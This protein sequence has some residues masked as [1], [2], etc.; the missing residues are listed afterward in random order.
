MSRLKYDRIPIWENKRRI[1]DLTFWRD[2]WLEGLFGAS[3]VITSPATGRTFIA[4]DR[5]TEL[6]RRIPAIREMVAL[7]E[8]PTLRDWVTFRKDDPPVRVDILEQFWYV[9]KLRISFRAPSDVIDEAVGKYQSD[10]HQSWIRTFNP[11]YW[12]GRGID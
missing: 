7:A 3:K 4:E 8:I 6:N 11:L 2:L 5:R 12:I 1:K 9:D 10:Q